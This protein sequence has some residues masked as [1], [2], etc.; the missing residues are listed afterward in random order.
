MITFKRSGKCNIEFERIIL[1]K[2]IS[3]GDLNFQKLNQL[4]FLLQCS[5]STIIHQNSQLKRVSKRKMLIEKIL[6]TLDKGT[7]T[8]FCQLT[9]SLITILL[10]YR[11]SFWVRKR[12]LFS[13]FQIQIFLRSRK[14]AKNLTKPMIQ[15]WGVLVWKYLFFSGKISEFKSL[16]AS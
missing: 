8:N 13:H 6:T 4:S 16:L 5:T 15:F 11:K 2:G 7:Y 1:P 12:S 9:H 14:E 10:R 3:S